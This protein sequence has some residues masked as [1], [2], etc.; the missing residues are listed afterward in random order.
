MLCTFSFVF[1]VVGIVGATIVLMQV[2]VDEDKNCSKVIYLTYVGFALLAFLTGGGASLI[3]AL[4]FLE[5]G[6][7]VTTVVVL[8]LGLLLIALISLDF[9]F[10]ERKEPSALQWARV[11]HNIAIRAELELEED[12]RERIRESIWEQNLKRVR[13]RENEELNIVM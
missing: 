5:F 8:G 6:Y 4:S 12:L 11:D 3:G 13:D 10:K 9:Y 2:A 7:G 1:S